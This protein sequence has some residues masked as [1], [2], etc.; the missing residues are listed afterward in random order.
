MD[1]EEKIKVFGIFINIAKQHNIIL[2]EDII[3]L[4]KIRQYDT[5][6]LELLFNNLYTCSKLIKQLDMRKLFYIPNDYFLPHCYVIELYQL[7][8]LDNKYDS[9]TIEINEIFKNIPE[10]N[11]LEL[12]YMVIQN[13]KHIKLVDLSLVIA[14][15]HKYNKSE[16][17]A[18]I[19]TAMPD[20]NIV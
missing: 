6:L 16:L 1:D 9:S 18:L 2:N 15:C 7:I 10:E 8:F 14:R 3:D 5:T 11:V 13:T 4:S 17:R 12:F 19:A 20:K